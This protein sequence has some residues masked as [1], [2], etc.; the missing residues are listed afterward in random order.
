MA[1]I[2]VVER[3]RLIG[4]GATGPTASG[5]SPIGEALTTAGKG[6]LAVQAERDR[7][8]EKEQ[9]KRERLEEKAR[10]KFERDRER[11]EDF[12]DERRFEALKES[13]GKRFLEAQNGATP[14]A[15]DFTRTH[16]TG[17]EE[18]AARYI[19]EAPERVRP[20]A[21]ARAAALRRA[22]AV[23]AT[24]WEL[25]ERDRY[26][27]SET[28]AMLN[29]QLPGAT[30]DNLEET[31][32]RADEIIGKAGLPPIDADAARKS[33][34]SSAQGAAVLKLPPADR[35][36]ALGVGPAAST[37][38]G[39][40]R[41]SAKSRDSVIRTIIAE[42]GSTGHTG[43]VAVGHVIRNRASAGRYGGRDPGSVVTAS[44]Q[45]EPWMT[46]EGRARMEGIATDS[47]AYQKAAAVVDEVFGGT[48]ADP[49]GGATHFYAPGAQAALGRQPPAWASGAP[50]ASVGGHQFYA[51]EGKVSVSSELSPADRNAAAAGRERAPPPAADAPAPTPVVD[52]R[53]ADIPFD[54]RLRLTDQAER[55]HAASV[56]EAAVRTEAEYD[57]RVSTLGVAI[58]RSQIGV[59]ELDGAYDEGNG[60]L[61]AQEYI[62][63]RNGINEATRTERDL[64]A[65]LARIQAGEKFNPFDSD[66]RR[67]AD[68][69]YNASGGA[70]G[71]LDT[72]APEGADRNAAA[73]GREQP[74]AAD[75]ARNKLRAWV[76]KAGV[77]PEAA[78]VSIRSAIASTDPAMAAR[79]LQ[80][81]AEALRVDSKAFDG[82]D[83]SQGL[84]NDAAAF[85]RLVE[86]VGLS[87]EEAARRMIER[88]DPEMKAKLTAGTKG[89]EGADTFARKLSEDDVA[90]AFANPQDRSWWNPRGWFDAESD[91][92]TQGIRD[93]ML[94][95]YR[96]IAYEAY[97]ERGDEEVAKGVAIARIKELYGV[98]WLTGAPL[99]MKFP[100]E[101]AYPAVDGSHD[102]IVNQ[103]RDAIRESAGK[104][105]P[106]ADIRLVPIPETEGA[107][108]TGR[109]PVYGLFYLDED[110]ASPGQMRLQTLLGQG[111]VADPKAAQGAVSDERRRALDADRARSEQVP[112]TREGLE[113]V[114][115]GLGIPSRDD[116][117]VP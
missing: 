13:E 93:S 3:S 90:E 50:L 31:Y 48:S 104:D 66:Q 7:L 56:R 29:K 81:A 79:G 108:R 83:G 17:F 5:S 39:V 76:S 82:R 47:T 106:A 10:D 102:Y 116:M 9:W 100:P 19:G 34:R 6:M 24:R 53:F 115:R 58:E 95:D 111:F 112:L 54:D 65:G 96:Q 35:I 28:G 57:A 113:D 70:A 15:K 64:A 22:Y 114:N 37:S 73:A 74:T 86:V 8:A 99:M 77:A 2:P 30:P 69:V 97:L 107:I 43:M 27:K 18:A 4:G 61:R 38:P 25:T 85:S 55:E 44:G 42:S 63:L 36:R 46:A 98:S 75:D 41:L 68:A 20:H 67:E 16:M 60:W 87:P 59:R 80:L 21:E 103:A 71:L 88:R 110:P 51:P 11:L 91:F 32:K 84:K 23:D 12:E 105:I 40:S 62:R 78:V 1:R 49:T 89:R 117:A 101:K 45:F 92:S 33:F 14:G 52:A 109:A 26:I 94:G 72:S